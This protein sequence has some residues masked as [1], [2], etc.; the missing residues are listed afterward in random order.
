MTGSPAADSARAEKLAEQA[1]AASPRS[2]LAHFAKGQVLRV[3]GRPKDA[4]P[5][6]ETVLALN[7][8]WVEAIAAIGRCKIFVGPIE[9]AIP[10]QEQAIR[11]SPRDPN[12][13]LWYFRIGQVHLLQSRIDE[14]IFWFGKACI[15]G[16][17]MPF[18]HA[19]LASAFGLKGETERA[20]AELTEARR[21]AGEGS[22]SSIAQLA[23]PQVFSRNRGN[24]PEIRALHEATYFVGL[25]K[26]GMPEE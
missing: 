26:A 7:P 17:G 19:H 2:P 10:A 1:L 22:Y 3:Q 18:F 11:L 20:A 16:P 21:L 8:N 24:R 13:G 4:I 23:D 6:Y 15:S 9:E 14:A 25:R 5:E 12:I